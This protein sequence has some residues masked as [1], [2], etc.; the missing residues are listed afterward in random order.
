MGFLTPYLLSTYDWPADLLNTREVVTRSV[1]TLGGGL[2]LETIGELGRVLEIV[3]SY[4]S[5][6]MEGNPTRIGDI[7]NAREGHLFSTKAGRNYQLEHLAHLHVSAFVRESA[8]QA[9]PC[10]REFLKEI[11]RRFYSALPDELR[12]ATLMTGEK[13]PIRPGEWRAAP[14]TVGRFQTPTPDQIDAIMEEFENAY[15][16]DRV[17]PVDQLGALAASHHRFL[18]AHPF[19][20]GNGRVARLMSDAMA[21]QW[22][23]G[24]R[25]LYSISRGLARRRAEY[26]S[27]LLM[28]E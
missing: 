16:P 19:S 10:S 23:F 9:R 26:D 22:G 8:S 17:E 2:S 14:A 1:T 3:N 15:S 28:P 5:N 6:R 12:F 27:A 11:H 21:L 18:W 13:V 7:F 20:D 24:G 4:A 25:G